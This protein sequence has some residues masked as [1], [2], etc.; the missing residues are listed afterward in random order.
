MK[1]STRGHSA[2]VRGRGGFS[3]IEILIA[4]TIL[5]VIVILASMVFQQTTGAYQ[6]GE[7]K[8]NAQVALRNILGSITRDLALAV[9]SSKYPGLDVND[10]GGG[11]SITFLALTGTP[12]VD[13]KGNVV[14]TAQKISYSYSGG[15]VKRSEQDTTCD[16]GTWRT[17]GSAVNVELNDAKE[18]A[19]SSFSFEAEGDGSLPENVRIRAEMETKDK[20]SS[21]GAGSGGKRGWDND[22]DNIYV[23][24]NPN[25]GN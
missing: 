16:N 25:K 14:R 20:I 3:L 11:S 10:I 1:L 8:V 15:V 21:V 13:E 19:L 6:T 22:A 7:R 2:P 24:L 4:T 9:D 12:R 18:S 23:G 17:V 5:L